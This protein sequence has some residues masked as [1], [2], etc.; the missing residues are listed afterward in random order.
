MIENCNRVENCH[1]IIRTLTSGGGIREIASLPDKDIDVDMSFRITTSVH[2]YKQNH[3]NNQHLHLL[4]APK[5]SYK[6]SISKNTIY[7]RWDFEQ[8]CTI[9]C[10][11]VKF[12]IND[13]NSGKDEW[14]VLLTNLDRAEFPLS[15][16][17]E[18][19]HMRWDIETSFRE[20]KYAL[21]AINFH[22]KKDDFIEMELYAH[23]IMFNAVSR[24]INMVKVQQKNHKDPYAIDFKMACS[25]I[26]KYFRLYNTQALND[27]HA[28]ILS[29]INPVRLGRKDKRKTVKAKSAI[30]FVYRVA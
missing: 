23:F 14:E 25:I 20:L 5:K 18:M 7:K 12:R 1:Y 17:K 26:R 19:Y 22:S 27:I 2:Y 15:R 28:E 13:P 6:T 4:R 10:R 29:Y 11:V 8:F 24:N 16:M 21:G 9:K 3:A 30:W